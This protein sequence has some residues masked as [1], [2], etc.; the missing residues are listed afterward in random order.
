MK[1]RSPARISPLPMIVNVAAWI[2]LAVLVFDW[3]NNNL[4]ANPIQ[5]ASQRTGFTALVF[6]ILSLACRPIYT[7]TKYA[8]VLKV[9]RDLGL[10]GW[11]YA[12]IHFLLFVG[13]DYG[14]N[15][16]WI[17]E[18]IAEKRFVI[19]GFLAF[20]LVCVLALTSF[21]WWMVRLGKRWKMLHRLVYLLNVLVVLHFALAIKGD[22][23][24]LQGDVVR[25]IIAGVIV[26][27]LLIS[28]IPSVRQRVNGALRVVPQPAVRKITR[29]NK[30]ENP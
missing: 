30:S 29:T 19:V 24:R 4:T 25:P 28:R 8:P 26:A 5:A 16:Q 18:A 13:L 11:M 2:P 7:L 27:L 6:L 14:F 10:Y 12:A 3:F 1:R 21:R 15:P 22:V 20:V 23:L 17:L 9:N